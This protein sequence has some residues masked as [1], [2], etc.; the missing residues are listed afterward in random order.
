MLAIA[1]GAAAAT[2]D[3]HAT[4]ELAQRQACLGCHTVEHRRVGPAFKAVAARY[5]GKPEAAKTLAAKILSGGKGS[6]GAVPMPAN[7]HVSADEARQLAEWV[8]SLR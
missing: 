7:D 3:S 4:L 1:L 6:W 5:I 8:L 2:G